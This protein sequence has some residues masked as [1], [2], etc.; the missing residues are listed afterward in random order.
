MRH[1]VQLCAECCAG[2]D[3]AKRDGAEERRR[4]T[5][6][7]RRQGAARTLWGGGRFAGGGE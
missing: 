2:S 5:C 6:K 4:D 1:K 3:P 7:A